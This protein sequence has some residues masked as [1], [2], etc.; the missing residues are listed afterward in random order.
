[1]WVEESGEVLRE[2]SKFYE[3][4]FKKEMD[5]GKLEE[6]VGGLEVR[7]RDKDRDGLIQEISERETLAALRVVSVN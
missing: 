2:I 5:R 3:G 7:V 6:V 1:M 4:L